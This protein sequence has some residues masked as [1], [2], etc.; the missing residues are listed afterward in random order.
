MSDFKPVSTLSIFNLESIE[1]NI[2]PESYGITDAEMQLMHIISGEIMY[3]GLLT[4]AKIIVT[5]IQLD[6]FLSLQNIKIH[7][8]VDSVIYIHSLTQENRKLYNNLNKQIEY[9]STE[10]FDDEDEEEVEIFRLL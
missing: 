6:E 1:L 10:N 9:L 3:S 4:D 2:V 7:K 5:E 8:I